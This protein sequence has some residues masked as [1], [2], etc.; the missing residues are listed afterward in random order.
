MAS[1]HVASTNEAFDKWLARGRPA[2]VPRAGAPPDEVFVRIHEAGGI[3]SLAHPGLLR[4]DDWVHEFAE[5]GL[6]AIEAYHSEHDPP[7]TATYLAIARRLHLGISGGSDYHADGSHGAAALGAVA[8]PA[9]EFED[10]QRR[11]AR[12]RPL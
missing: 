2:F 11:A 8:L 3:A 9:A 10:L 7:M 12:R 1:G 4:H 6:D 5:A